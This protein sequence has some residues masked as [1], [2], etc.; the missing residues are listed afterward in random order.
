M[1]R[2]IWIVVT[3]MVAM[4]ACSTA[5]NRKLLIIGKGNVSA[6]GNEIT[7]KDGSGY[8]E[9]TI[10]VEGKEAVE[11]KVNGSAATTSVTVPADA[12]FYIL[13]LKT[14]TLVGSEQNINGQLSGRTITQEELKHTIDSL[15][16]LVQGSNV[17]ASGPNYLI[18]PNKLQKISGSMNAMV[19]GPFTKIPG[20]IETDADGKVPPIFKFYTN[21]EMR[22]LIENLKKQTI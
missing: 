15:S 4:G 21:N 22:E 17:S 11:Y 19:F 16:Q 9:H 1:N 10:T 20:S 14:D 5:E 2:K 8:A 6:S 13:N 7:L 18:A 3:A 12:G